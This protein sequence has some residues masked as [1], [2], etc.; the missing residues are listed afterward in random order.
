[1]R[2]L[3]ASAVLLAG[4]ETLGVRATSRSLYFSEYVE[5]SG[6][7]NRAVEICNGHSTSVDLSDGS[8]LIMVRNVGGST[9]FNSPSTTFSLSGV[10]S[11]GACIV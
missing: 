10:L 8:K 9:S 1:M 7:Y 2:S 4:I 6:S 11:A 5:G 3:L